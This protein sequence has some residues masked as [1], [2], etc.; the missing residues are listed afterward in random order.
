MRDGI[1]KELFFT[2]AICARITYW[3]LVEGW[4]FFDIALTPSDWADGSLILPSNMLP[5]MLK[6]IRLLNIGPRNAEYPNKWPGY[7]GTGGGGGAAG[8]GGEDYRMIRGPQ[9]PVVAGAGFAPGG[10][11]LQPPGVA[12]LPGAPPDV[13]SSK[14]PYQDWQLKV[15]HVHPKIIHYLRE[16]YEKFR[17]KLHFSAVCKHMGAPMSALPTLENFSAEGENGLCFLHLSGICPF[18]DSCQRSGSHG[19]AVSDAFAD[20][21]ISTIRRGVEHVFNH[22]PGYSAQRGIKR[23]RD[24]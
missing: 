4:D 23:E 11:A 13:P 7:V 9:R 18:G 3:I 10:Y 5:S 8:S 15:G 2:P 19:V 14:S 6:P 1:V 22:G 24:G 16:F 21:F 12:G 17:G 20:R